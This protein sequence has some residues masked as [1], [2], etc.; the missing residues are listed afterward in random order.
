[1]R[2]WPTAPVTGCSPPDNV[3]TAID[4][5]PPLTTPVVRTDPRLEAGTF[6]LPPVALGIDPAST[7]TADGPSH[8]RPLSEG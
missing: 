8:W 5:M 2:R 6:N 4:E 7:P 3:L 1:M